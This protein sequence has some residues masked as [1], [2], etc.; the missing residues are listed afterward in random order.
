MTGA[1]L[2]RAA[3]ALV[4]TR[5]RLGGRDPVTG[6]DCIGLLEAALHDCGQAA[7][8]PN[9]YTLRLAQLAPW[10][11]DPAAVGFAPAA[12]PFAPGDVVLLGVGPAQFHLAIH[13]AGGGW[14]H[15][16]AA[17]RR[18]VHQSARPVGAIVHHW[19]PA[20]CN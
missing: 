5:F 1:D 18:V 8:M 14:I 16:H 9:G 10:L 17:L 20:P 13:A 2:A 12:P 15:A 19:R 7:V 4:G 3:L 11:P 6:L